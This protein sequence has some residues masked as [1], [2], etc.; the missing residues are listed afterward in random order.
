MSSECLHVFDG[1][2]HREAVVDC[3]PEP[4]DPIDKAIFYL[5]NEPADGIKNE[6]IL[7]QNKQKGSLCV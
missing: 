3:M 4:D 7:I 5:S 1:P 6:N 2:E